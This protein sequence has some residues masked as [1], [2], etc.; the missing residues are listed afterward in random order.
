MAAARLGGPVPDGGYAALSERA[1]ERFRARMRERDAMPQRAKAAVDG[2]A[3]ALRPGSMD[4]AIPPRHLLFLDLEGPRPL[5]AVAVGEL[6]AADLVTW[7]LSGVG[8]APETA[9][10]GTVREAGQLLLEQRVVGVGSPAVVAWLGYPAPTLAHAVLDLRARAAAERFSHELQRFARWRPDGPRTAVEA[11]SYGATVAAHGLAAL[12]A[13]R[14]SGTVSCLATTGSAGMP[15]RLAADPSLL[16]VPAHRVFE[17]VAADDALARLGRRLSGRTR[18]AGRVFD[19][20]GRPGLGLLPVTGHNTSRFVP[21]AGRPRYGYR[22]PGTLSL[23][24]LALVT[25]GLEPL[26]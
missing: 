23:R 26:A 14:A 16:G 6:D 19:V 21:G 25:A 2:V 17:A 10:W 22:D 3:H 7:Q 9:M 4:A 15:R 24:N 12:A 13:E 11:H 18:P 1:M 20:D 5:A 8:I